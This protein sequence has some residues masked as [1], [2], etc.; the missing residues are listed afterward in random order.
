MSRL[1]RRLSTLLLCSLLVLGVW[2]TQPLSVQAAEIRNKVDD[3]IAETAGKVDLNNASVRRFQ[4]Y[5]GMYP[6]LAGKIVVGGPYDQVDDVLKLDLTE[7]QKELFEKYKEN[8]TVTD[9]EI[10][11]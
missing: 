7:R 4:Q 8:F 9:P 1:F 3:K 2:L 10:A 5:P 11:L 6:T